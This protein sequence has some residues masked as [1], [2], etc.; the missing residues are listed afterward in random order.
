MFNY[1]AEEEIPDFLY[2]KV[3]FE[4]GAKSYFYKVDGREFF[5][6]V[7]SRIKDELEKKGEKN[8]REMSLKTLS[9]LADDFYETKGKLSISPFLSPFEE[10][11]PLYVLR[12]GSKAYVEDVS[13]KEFDDASRN[14]LIAYVPEISRSAY[15]LFGEM[16]WF[17][18]DHLY[19]NSIKEVKGR[20][21]IKEITK[22]EEKTK[23]GKENIFMYYTD[24]T[25]AS[26]QSFSIGVRNTG[27]QFPAIK[28][29]EKVGPVGNIFGISMFSQKIAVNIKGKMLSYENGKLSDN[30]GM[31]INL[32]MQSMA[33][34]VK[35][36]TL[37]EGDI[38]FNG[39]DLVFVKT[40][41][42]NSL[43]I[44][45]GDGNQSSIIQVSTPMAPDL[46]YITQVVNPFSALFSKENKENEE[47]GEGLFDNP[48]MMMAM[49]G[50]FGGNQQSQDGNPMANMM[51]MLMMS[52]M[53]K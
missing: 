24:K 36:S 14:D 19:E 51:S 53:M 47:D 48:M 10:K 25:Q 5:V 17:Y 22:V 33:I 41:Y 31:T 38:V 52:K 9:V 34:P 2:L 4:D 35:R 7:L 29:F 6:Y 21:E 26:T 44:I 46:D 1:F 11:N 23:D 45:D 28:G 20:L 37:K 3:R 16:E 43:T 27:L 15:D 32:P 49:M 30:T 40:V 8:T 12:N 39:D 50:G 13:T 18:E 42:S